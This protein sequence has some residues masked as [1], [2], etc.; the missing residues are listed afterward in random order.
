MAPAPQGRGRFWEVGGGSGHRLDRAVAESD[1]W[2]LLLRRGE[3]LALGGHLKGAL[4]AFAA[5]L[6]RGAP[7]RPECLGALVDCL[8]FNYR[9][10][11]GLSWSAAPTA[12]ADGGAGGL[13]SCL[14]CRGFLSEPVT[15]PCGHSYCRRCLR[16][17][18]RARCRLCRDRLPP[19]TASATDAEGT[20]PRPP[21]LAAAIAASDFRTSVVLNHL[22]E[23]WFPGQRER[24]RAA[25]RLGELLHQGRYREALAAACEALRAGPADLSLLAPRARDPELVCALGGSSASP[26]PLGHRSVGYWGAGGCGRGRRPGVLRSQWGSPWKPTVTRRGEGRSAR[27]SL[28]RG[29]AWVTGTEAAPARDGVR[30]LP[31]ERFPG[32]G[33]RAGPA[34]GKLL[35]GR[36]RILREGNEA[37]QAASPFPT[38]KSHRDNWEPREGIIA[39]VRWA[40][41]ELRAGHQH[42]QAPQAAELGASGGFPDPEFFA[43]LL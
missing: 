21:P 6:R 25:G 1:R 40:W 16:R 29:L 32:I 3:L 8:V 26:R 13:L 17:E 31:A 20:A 36:E 18:F 41:R 2:E 19:A 11:H 43:T 30:S 10:R 39:D 33:S 28:D 22:A 12:G 27:G 9:L 37:G 24:A 5:A 15:V 4:E 42:R 34:A 14:G 7:A 35:P 23:K 38:H